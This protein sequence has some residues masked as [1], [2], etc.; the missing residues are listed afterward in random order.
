[1]V[2]FAAG[3]AE[4]VASLT[5]P[6]MVLVPL[7]ATAKVVTS[8]LKINALSEILIKTELDHTKVYRFSKQLAGTPLCSNLEIRLDAD[9]LEANAVRPQ[10]DVGPEQPLWRRAYPNRNAVPR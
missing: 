10:G 3:T 1:M 5:V 6:E 9:N 4:P 7:C 2:T 8:T